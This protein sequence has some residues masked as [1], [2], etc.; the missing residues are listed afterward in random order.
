VETPITLRNAE[1]TQNR[2]CRISPATNHAIIDFH[3]TMLKRYEVS[4][5][6]AIVINVSFSANPKNLAA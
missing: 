3:H 6:A 1:S 5:A 4:N 2:T